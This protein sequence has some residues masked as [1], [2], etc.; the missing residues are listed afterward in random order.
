MSN[1]T[2]VVTRSSR[3]VTVIQKTSGVTVNSQGPQ[4]P[5]GI[6]GPAGGSFY[7]EEDFSSTSSVVFNH[8]LNGYPSI[9]VIIGG[10]SVEADITYNSVNQVSVLF[11][12]SQSGKVVAS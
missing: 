1:N 9:T 4:G 5:P 8:N 6:Q 7:A 2:V 12:T 3:P 10:I 11:A